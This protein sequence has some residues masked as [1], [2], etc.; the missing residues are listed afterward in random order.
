MKNGERQKED[1]SSPME[2][3]MAEQNVWEQCGSQA[4]MSL[5]ERIRS[6]SAEVGIIGLGNVGLTEAIEFVRVGFRV[7]GFDIDVNRIRNIQAGCSYL[8]D[9]SDQELSLA[10]ESGRLQATG[11]FSL[12]K[13]MDAVPIAVPTPSAKQKLRIFPIFLMPS[14]PSVHA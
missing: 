1:Y 13:E 10:V 14:M 9:I 6:Q 2:E 5:Q 8:V 12:L 4:V 7:T 3:G 11:N